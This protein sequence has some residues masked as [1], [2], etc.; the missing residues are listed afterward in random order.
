MSRRKS[1]QIAEPPDFPRVSG[2]EPESLENATEGL[3][4]S[5]RERG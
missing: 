4:F 2:D 3:I 1:K 5:P